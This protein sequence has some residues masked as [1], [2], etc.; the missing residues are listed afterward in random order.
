MLRSKGVNIKMNDERMKIL[1]M[2]EQGTITSAQAAELLFALEEV[3]S[4]EDRNAEYLAPDARPD[5]APH[6]VEIPDPDGSTGEPQ[7]AARPQ[8]P[9]HS[10]PS[11]PSKNFSKWRNWW[12]YPLTFGIMVTIFSGWLLFLGNQNEWAGFW[13]ACIWLPLLLGISVILLSWLSHSALW[14]HVRVN[15]GQEEWPRRIAISLPLPLRFGAWL[16]R[17][18]QDKIPGIPDLDDVPLDDLITAIL[19]GVKPD[20]P[21]YIEVEEG[22]GGERVEVY[23]G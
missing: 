17:T 20:A 1:E 10:S 19:D 3:D 6:L 22:K 12:Y 18:F 8:T 16:F 13:M 15:T 9:K 11:S 5:T 2:V 23:I 14:A 7:A 4:D 21:I